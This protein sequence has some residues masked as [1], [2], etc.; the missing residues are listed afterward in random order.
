MHSFGETCLLLICYI[1]LRDQTPQLLCLCCNAYHLC[2]WLAA[3]QTSWVD[4]LCCGW[5]REGEDD[6]ENKEEK[7]IKRKVQLIWKQIKWMDASSCWP[8]IR[9][10]FINCEVNYW[11]TCVNKLMLL[12]LMQSSEMLKGPRMKWKF[13]SQPFWSQS[14]SNWAL[15][16]ALTRHPKKL[17]HSNFNDVSLGPWGTNCTCFFP[18][19]DWNQTGINQPST[20]LFK[21]IKIA[22]VQVIKQWEGRF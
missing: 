16:Q 13:P 15:F 5:W 12:I 22:F 10:K 20:L 17:K 4:F 14:S 1:V 11:R 6:P 2:S 8:R 19:E 9:A 21:T 18:L 7:V 3:P